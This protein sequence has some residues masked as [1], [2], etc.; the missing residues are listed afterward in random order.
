[1]SE[2]G[3]TPE[4]ARTRRERA[5]VAGLVVLAVVM[6]LF[7][8]LNVKDVEVNWIFGK[9]STPLIVVIVVSLLVGILLTHFAEARYRRRR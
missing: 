2:P 8:V 9:S 1:M 5:R 3:Q 4:Q 7:A 6:T